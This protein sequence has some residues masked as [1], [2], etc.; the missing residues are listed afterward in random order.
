MTKVNIKRGE[1]LN[2]QPVTLQ[3]IVVRPINRQKQDITNWRNAT[4]SAES[5]VPRRVTLYDLYEDITSTDA[6]IISV[7]GKRVDAVTSAKWLF[8]DKNGK[9]VDEVNQLIDCIGFQ[10][11]LT[12]ILNSK[13]WGYTMMEPSFFMNDNDQHEMQA[14]LVPRKH[15]RPETGI[16]ADEQSGD[17]GLNIREGIY[18]KTVM[19]VGNPKDL[20][21]LLSAA[22]YAIYKRGDIGDWAEF[23]EIFGRGIIDATWDGF[24][25]NQRAALAT[26]LNEMGGGG[27]IIR[28]EGTAIDIKGNQGNANGQLQDSFATKMDGYISKALLGS[29]ETTDS[30]SSSGYAQSKVHQD[31]DVKKN[32]SDI[33]FVRRVLNSRFIKCL[34]AAGFNVKG[35][36][37]IIESDKK[38]SKKESYEIHKSIAKDLG[39]PIDDNFFYETYEMPKPANYE[40]LKAKK[41][42]QVEKQNAN[43]PPASAEESDKK[44]DVSDKKPTAKKVK[45]A[46]KL[47]LF[48]LAELPVIR[49]LLR[50][51]MQAP[52][53]PTGAETQ[54]S[55]CSDHLIKLIDINTAFD[56]EAL[57][58]RFWSGNGKLTFDVPLFNYTAQALLKGFQTG[59]RNNGGEIK[60]VD[61]G[62][63]YDSDDPALITAF[64]MNLFKFSAAKTLAEAQRFNQLL[65]EAKT[66]DIFKINARNTANVYNNTW[67]QTELT[68]AILVANATVNQQNLLNAQDVFPYWELITRRDDHV[69]ETH[70]QLD[71][72]ILPANDPLWRY[73]SPLLGWGCRCRLAGRMESEVVDVDFA[74]MRA[75]AEAYFATDEFIRSKKQ[76]FGINRANTGEVFTSNQSYVDSFDKIGTPLNKLGAEVYGLKSFME[77]S[78][79]ATL[80]MPEALEDLEQFLKDNPTLLDYHNRKLTIS[81]QALTGSF[82]NRLNAVKNALEKPDEVWINGDKLDEFVSI[83][84]YT[85]QTLIT[86]STVKNGRTYEV[87][88]WVPVDIDTDIEDY[89]RGL[90]VYNR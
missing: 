20:G 15:M 35:G 6:Q 25:E 18:A 41:L 68:T 39:L 50:S 88:N 69:R 82:K 60:L 57:I 75:K 37:F 52:A 56:N 30:S 4:R 9:P 28:P 7:W 65:R 17:T 71:G 33:N 77:A 5:R 61:L 83:K 46:D 62:F 36:T 14:N 16:I 87:S 21:L 86:I 31:E 55:C 64:E 24:D 10:D 63:I 51:F 54:I 48:T 79:M 42:K 81:S 44:E 49:R 3:Q 22:Q 85:D 90:L 89:R 11:L 70:R 78:D 53:N 29:T 38:L 80:K 23:I 66:Q 45:L 12:E 84:Y 73:L 8:T 47:G 27:I 59:W 40:Q 67:L 43:T 19:E 26:S 1:D 58:D 74:K 76:G 72:L 34:I 32:D 2:K 13:S